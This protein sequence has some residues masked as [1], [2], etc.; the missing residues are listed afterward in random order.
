MARDKTNFPTTKTVRTSQKTSFIP[1][2]T[3]HKPLTL[4]TQ[5]TLNDNF[6]RRQ[7]EC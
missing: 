5:T 3:F 2:A 6:L 4:S 1:F 7:H